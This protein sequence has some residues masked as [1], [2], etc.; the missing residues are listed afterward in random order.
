M[1][2]VIS[3]NLNGYIVVDPI[4]KRDSTGSFYEEYEENKE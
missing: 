3:E 1:I 2:L 4:F